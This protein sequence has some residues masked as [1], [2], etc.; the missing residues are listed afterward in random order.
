MSRR[1][2]VGAHY[3]AF[4]RAHERLLFARAIVVIILRLRRGVIPGVLPGAHPAA[5]HAQ[6]SQ[7]GAQLS[8]RAVVCAAAHRAVRSACMLAGGRRR[9]LVIL[10]RLAARL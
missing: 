3:G 6:T 1:A 2:K 4:S 5:A 10:G 7:L 9:A 8:A